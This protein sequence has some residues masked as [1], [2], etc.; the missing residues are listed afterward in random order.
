[1]AQPVRALGA[2]LL[3]LTLAA[4]GGGASSS[5]APSVPGGVTTPT[6][7]P[8]P[9]SGG[10]TA[11]T[12]SLGSSGLTLSGPGA[13][14]TFGVNPN[15]STT[16]P[17]I[18]ATYCNGIATVSG[19]GSSLPETLTVAGA[20]NGA[21]SLVLYNGSAVATFP[22]VVGNAN[23]SPASLTASPAALSFAAAGAAAQTVSV[24]APAGTSGTAGID[25]AACANIANVTG[26][27]GTL[28][29]QTFTV[30][31][32]ATGTCSL[33]VLDGTTATTVLVS[34]GQTTTSAMLTLTPSSLTFASPAAAAQ[35]TTVGYQGYVGSVSY[36]T[37]CTGIATF[38]VPNGPL[39]QTATVTPVAAGTCSVVFSATN[40][41]SVSL[42]ITVQ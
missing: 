37:N 24:S 17:T 6:P 42:A 32:V 2:L 10:S 40:A 19:G 21:C 30:A 35:T 7:T 18:D 11:G 26:T 4:C 3:T 29:S 20:G 31:P 27:S 28:P 5:P 34:V 23:T 16:P 33:V 39:P 41:P 13:T 15:G 8:A 14:G 36:S 1:M 25:A 22:I 9:G 12:F 38:S